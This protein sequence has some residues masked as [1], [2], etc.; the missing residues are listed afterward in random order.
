MSHEL[1]VACP[2]LNSLLSQCN[3]SLASV[4]AMKTK[5]LKKGS[6]SELFAFALSKTCL[7]KLHDDL[8]VLHSEM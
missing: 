4:R 8:P 3:K 1:R 5:T 6:L 7:G 2:A